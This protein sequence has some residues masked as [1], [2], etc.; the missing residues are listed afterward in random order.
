VTGPDE[1]TP[2][3]PVKPDESTEKP[4][5][6][7]EVTAPTVSSSENAVHYSVQVAAFGEKKN[8][9]ESMKKLAAETDYEVSLAP[10]ANGKLTLL[11]VGNY[12]D[13][14]SAEKVCGELRAR[15]GFSGCFVKEH[16]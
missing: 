16:H 6:T 11:F 2:A 3:T 12:P 15:P 7:V 4:V 10:S 5:A 8:A 13:R 1:T 14:E 9:E